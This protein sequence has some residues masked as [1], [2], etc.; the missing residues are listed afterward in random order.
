MSRREMAKLW[1][2]LKIGH[3]SEVPGLAEQ[4]LKQGIPEHEAATNSVAMFIA[5]VDTVRT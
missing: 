5:G 1:S 3:E 4:W 2:Q